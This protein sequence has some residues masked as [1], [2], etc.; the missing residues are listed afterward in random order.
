M[1]TT[2]LGRTGLEVTRIGFGGIPIQR[3]TLEAAAEVVRKAMAKK[4]PKPV[5]QP[6]K[7]AKIYEGEEEP[8][9]RR[10]HSPEEMRASSARIEKHFEVLGNPLIKPD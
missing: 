1:Q 5:V 4:R 2:V 8:F 3:L 6:T 9:V 7:P 10:P